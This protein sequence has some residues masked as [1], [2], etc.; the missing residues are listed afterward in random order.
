MNDT[1][2]DF[3][4]NKIDIGDT[5]IFCEPNYREFN[6]GK[7]ISKSEKTCQIEYTQKHRTRGVEVCRQ[8]YG[9]II[10]LSAFK[11]TTV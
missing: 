6:F 3:L 10:K 8:S 4:G 5:V 7:V 9:Q 1:Q 2:A 11:T